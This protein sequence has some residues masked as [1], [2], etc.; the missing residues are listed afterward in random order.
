MSARA[1]TIDLA[2]PEPGP[3][4]AFDSSAQ[5]MARLLANGFEE[6]ELTGLARY[7]ARLRDGVIWD[8][9][10]LRVDDDAMFLVEAYQWL[11]AALREQSE[12]QHHVYLGDGCFE[13]TAQCLPDQVVRVRMGEYRME[14][15]LLESSEGVTLALE[16]YVSLWDTIAGGLA[17]ASLSAGATG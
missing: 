13:I 5:V 7:R 1:F 17:R 12:W 3:V 11:Q 2:R 10:V 4:V 14:R 16:A 15:P 6:I 8:D 9:M